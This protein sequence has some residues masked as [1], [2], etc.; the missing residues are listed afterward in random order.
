[1]E[2]PVAIVVA[3]AVTMPPVIGNAEHT[4]DRAHGAA[5]TGTDRASDDPTDGAGDPV[6]LMSTLLRAAHDALGVA[7]MGHS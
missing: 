1:M 3:V 6:T 7:G 4:L 2:A 5:D